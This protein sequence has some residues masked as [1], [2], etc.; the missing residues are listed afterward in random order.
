MIYQHRNWGIF[1]FTIYN[2]LCFF[3]FSLCAFIGLYFCDTCMSNE[4]ISIPA[5][6][7]H[8][9]DFKPYPVSKKA[10]DYIKEIKDHPVIDFKVIALKYKLLSLLG[11]LNSKGKNGTLYRIILFSVFLSG[12]RKGIKLKS[13]SNTKVYGLLKL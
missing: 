10:F 9:W 1:N 11:F 7:V 4:L 2:I 6:I 3:S 5:R 13:I 12:T 8:N